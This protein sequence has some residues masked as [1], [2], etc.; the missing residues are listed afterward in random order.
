MS[1]N[2]DNKNKDFRSPDSE[3]LEAAYL[4]SLRKLGIFGDTE[5]TKAS[6]EDHHPVDAK[7]YKDP[8]QDRPEVY[9]KMVSEI[10][11]RR[12]TRSK[13]RW[14][15]EPVIPVKKSIWLDDQPE[16]QPERSAERRPV[17][18]EPER[19]SSASSRRRIR[20]DI[21]AEPAPGYRE[22]VPAEQVSSRVRQRPAGETSSRTRQRPA[23]E[24]SSRTRQRPADETS[25]RTRQRPAD[26][27]SSRTRQRSSGEMPS[28]TRA[29]SRRKKPKYKRFE[30]EFSFINAVVCML[31]V[32]GVGIALIAM[33]RESGF[34]QS[35]NRNLAEMPE[36]S[37]KSYFNGEYTEGITKYYTD[38]IPNRESLKTFSD[39]F[40]G[41]FGISLDDVKIKGDVQAGKKETL[42]DDKKTTTTK[43]TLYTGPADTE[44]SNTTPGGGDDSSGEKTT[45]KTTTTKA[46]TTTKKKAEVPDEGEWAGNVVLTGEGTPNIRAMPAFYGMFSVGEK[47]ANVLNSYKQALGDK[48][49][50]FNVYCPLSSAYYMPKSMEEEFTNQHD[51][52]LNVGGYL[53]NVINVDVYNELAEHTDEYIYSRT[54]HHWQPRGAYYAMK[55]FVEDAGLGDTYKDLSTYEK[56]V[57]EGFCGTMYAFSDYVQGL[58]DY[59]DQMI[60]YK[61]DNNDQLE[62]NYWDS[63]FSYVNESKGHSL[64]FDWAEGVNA[65]GAILGN[66]LDICE[67]KTGVHNGRVLVILKD[68]YANATIPFLTHS[69]EKIYVA[70]FRY[71]DISMTEFAKN[72]GA[73]DMAFIV[74]ISG[75]HTETHIDAIASDK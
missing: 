35:E 12:E 15:D 2:R 13:S 18:E 42:D 41:L 36:F 67:V 53:Q 24:T 63:T 69:F 16:P 57:I 48:V 50:V 10:E 49:N 74:S 20:E 8:E 40:S 32:F 4:D 62:V 43:V 44:P 9:E 51:A 58:K 60:Y 61:P 31:L 54:D 1:D 30:T 7:D 55:K 73:T 21:P 66:D 34:I 6:R 11:K 39:T 46:T 72:V 19:T 17:R 25:S 26:E 71:V 56:C 52:I 5:A 23:E 45:T 33:K 28:R 29:A 27:T 3:K 37:L 14:S 47:Y 70:D 68:S 64:F 59:P 38:T 65:Y 75:G 22:E